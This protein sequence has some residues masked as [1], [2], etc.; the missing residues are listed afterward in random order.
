VEHLKG[1]F[2][3]YAPALLA[4]IRLVLKDIHY[5]NKHFSSSEEEQFYNRRYGTQHNDTQH[6]DIQHNLIY[7][8]QCVCV[9]ISAIEIQTTGPISMKFGMGILLNTGKVHS[10]VATPYPDPQG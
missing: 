1:A 10:C 5:V 8:S 3:R 2:V 7:K 4:N 6:N 9:C